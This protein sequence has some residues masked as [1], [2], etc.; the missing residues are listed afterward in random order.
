VIEILARELGIPV[1]QVSKKGSGSEFVV[2]R[3]KD[4]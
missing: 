1:T 4:I 2:R 3:T